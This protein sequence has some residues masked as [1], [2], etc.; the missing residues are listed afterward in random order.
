SGYGVPAGYTVG[1]PV[2]APPAPSRDPQT[3]RMIVEKLLDMA[4]I[5]PPHHAFSQAIEKIINEVRAVKVPGKPL[6]VEGPPGLAKGTAL[7]QYVSD[8]GHSQPA[9]YLQRSVVLRK[10]HGVSSIEEDADKSYT[11]IETEMEAEIG[12]A[13]NSGDDINAVVDM[14]MLTHV[15]QALRI[16]ASKSTAGPVLLVIDDTSGFCSRIECH[17]EKY[18]GIVEVFNW[19]LRKREQSFLKHLQRHMPIRITKPGFTS[20]P[21]SKRSGYRPPV[22]TS[23]KELWEL[24]LDI[25]FRGGIL[26]VAQL[27]VQRMALVEVLVERNIL[28]WR[29]GR[30]RRRENWPSM[31]AG[32]VPPSHA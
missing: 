17:Y 24:F 3:V 5:E 31:R 25:N 28:H 8:E 30:I 9:I 4:P 20:P 7:Q 29:D 26:P 19:L 10:N 1:A 27:D 18:E 16:I 32:W 22:L 12:L 14:T 2:Q 13:S 6:L 21:S 23:E 15:A 11:E